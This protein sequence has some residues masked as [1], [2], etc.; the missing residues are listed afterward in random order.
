VATGEEGL[1][2]LRLLLTAYDEAIPLKKPWLPRS[3]QLANASQHWK[4]S[5]LRT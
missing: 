4:S 2:V 1:E 3:E 5:E